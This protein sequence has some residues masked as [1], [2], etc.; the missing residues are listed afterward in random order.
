MNSNFNARKSS[1]LIL[2]CVV[3]AVLGFGCKANNKPYNPD[4]DF[5]VIE[6]TGAKEQSIITYYDQDFNRI[7]KQKVPYGGMTDRFSLATVYDGSMFAT[8]EGREDG[9]GTHLSIKMD[10]QTGE[11][12]ELDHGENLNGEKF[13]T[14]DQERIFVNTNLNGDTYLGYYDTKTNQSK[15]ITLKNIVLTDMVTDENYLY[16]FGQE[17]R[18]RTASG[19]LSGQIYFFDKETLQMVDQKD[20]GGFYSMVFA[21]IYEGDLYFPLQNVETEVSSLCKFN[22]ETGEKT[23]I[24]FPNNLTDF[25]NILVYQDQIYISQGCVVTGEGKTV[26]VYDPKK[27]TMKTAEFDHDLSQIEIKH[28]TLYALDYNSDLGEAKLYKYKINGQKFSPI[29]STDVYTKKGSTLP[30]FYVGCFFVK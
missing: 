29:G 11:I 22:T 14:V 20:L 24:D 5:A 1:I 2:L 9:I 16:A 21:T 25:S 18:Y 15:S 26:V 6:S 4:Y 30:Y 3:A 13:S 17:D 19:S 7:N 12:K 10:L 27:G 28:D 8:P 23:L